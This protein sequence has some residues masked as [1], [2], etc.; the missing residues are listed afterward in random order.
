MAE[1]D[2]FPQDV[3]ARFIH[4]AVDIEGPVL[5]NGCIGFR[6]SVRARSPPSTQRCDRVSLI[7][8]RRSVHE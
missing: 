1:A 3:C 6:T 8:L 5:Q 7:D 2:A 4:M